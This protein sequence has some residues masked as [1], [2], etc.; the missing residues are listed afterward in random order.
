M[1]ASRCQIRAVSRM[2]KISAGN[3]TEVVELYFTEIKF[4]VI[5]LYTSLINIIHKF[6]RRWSLNGLLSVFSPGEGEVGYRHSC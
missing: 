2:F 3:M 6:L 1:V 5:C 4:L